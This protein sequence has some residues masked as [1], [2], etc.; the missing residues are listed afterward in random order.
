VEVHDVGGAFAEMQGFLTPSLKGGNR[1][2]K[3]FDALAYGAY[4]AP[5]RIAIRV[6]PRMIKQMPEQAG[7]IH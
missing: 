7:A 6:T 2:P 3:R 5:I 4:V 1:Q